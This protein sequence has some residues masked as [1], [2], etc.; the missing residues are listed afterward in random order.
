[1]KPI[2]AFILLCYT[3]SFGTLDFS[4]ATEKKIAQR[5]VLAIVESKDVEL[6]NRII[7]KE[8]NWD[9]RA[10]NPSTMDIGL[11]QVSMK[12]HPECSRDS[13]F[14]IEYNIA[15]GYRILKEGVAMGKKPSDV[16]YGLRRS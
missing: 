1:M 4:C 13:L 2:L 7:E 12:Y 8:S 3:L 11:M 16:F 6:V 14:N 5:C 10:V 9:T 15:H